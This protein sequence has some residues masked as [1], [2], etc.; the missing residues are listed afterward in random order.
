MA[1]VRNETKD[2]R[3]ALEMPYFCRLMIHIDRNR[4]MGSSTLCVNDEMDQIHFEED[5]LENGSLIFDENSEV[6]REY[7]MDDIEPPDT[8]QFE[9]CVR[10]LQ[11]LGYT[12][13]HSR[14]LVSTDNVVIFWRVMDD[15]TQ[16]LREC[17]EEIAECARTDWWVV[18]KRL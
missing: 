5:V 15:D 14:N 2:Y 6:V 16:K 11:R 9:V 18:Y 4:R 17:D 13:L 3:M 10:V 7:V 8:E 12:V 1:E